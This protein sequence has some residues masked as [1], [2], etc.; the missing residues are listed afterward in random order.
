MTTIATKPRPTADVRLVFHPEKDAAYVHFQHAAAVPFDAQAITVLRRNAWW[1]ADAALLTYWSPADVK[2]RFKA[3]GFEAQSIDCEGTQCYIATGMG[4]AIVAFRG[5]QP[6][7]WRDIL[8]DIRVAL[9]PWDR[10][11]TRV[12]AGFKDALNRLWPQLGPLVSEL[13]RTMRVWFTGHSLGAALA[14]LAADRFPGT[15]GV[16]TVGLPRVGDPRFAAQFDA[17]FGARALRYVRNTD[18]VTQVPTPLPLPYRHVGDLRQIAR[19]GTIL[20]QRPTLAHFISDLVGDLERLRDVI[21]ALETGALRRAPA[22]LLDHMP[23]GYAVDIW[24]D[25]TTNGD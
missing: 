1:L 23:A 5:T 11:D 13:G 3:A 6:D 16:V 8:D 25:F 24:N 22:F 4:A 9:V 12:H 19:D 18:V 20:S 17:R 2:S 7:Q 10:P 15:A 14:T 21:E